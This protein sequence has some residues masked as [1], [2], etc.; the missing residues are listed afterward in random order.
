MIRKEVS[1]LANDK[2]FSFAS[3]LLVNFAADIHHY[4]IYEGPKSGSMDTAALQA[5][6]DA[7][8]VITHPTI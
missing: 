7:R 4:I 1:W 8:E 3:T 2:D 6:I 5:A